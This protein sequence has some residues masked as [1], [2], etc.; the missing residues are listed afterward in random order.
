MTRATVD[1][2]SLGPKLLVHHT[3]LALGADEAGA[4]P[5]LALVRQVLGEA[6]SVQVGVTAS[7]VCLPYSQC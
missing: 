2:V 3:G 1:L 6:G 7:Y 5:V 4:V